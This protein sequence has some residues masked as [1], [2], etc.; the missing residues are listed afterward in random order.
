MNNVYCWFGGSY[1]ILTDNGTEFKNDLIDQVAKELGVEHKIFTPPYHPQSNGKI[2]AFH[3][4]LK[5]CIA[6]H[7]NQL[8]EWDEVV[9]LACAA[10]NFLP[11]EYS[12]ESPFFLMFGRDPILPLNKLLQP[13]IR[14]LGND[15]NILSLETLQ[16][17]YEL[18]ATNLTFARQ[19][20]GNKDPIKESQIKEGDLVLIK[21]NTKRGFQPRFLD[22]YRVV[23]IK[24]QQVEVRPAIGGDTKW[25]H[26]TH[27]KP[28]LPA[29]NVIASLPD[30]S[31]FGRKTTLRLNPDK[32]PDLNWNIATQLNTTLTTTNGKNTN[33]MAEMLFTSTN[34]EEVISFP[35][36]TF[37]V[38]RSK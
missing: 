27:V 31:A 30:Y 6:K 25:A 11:N 12:R 15:E 3:Y 5:A 22:N 21:N 10:Y 32:I 34:I 17:L 23:R 2:E 24:G 33:V 35:F 7:I 14:Y 9:P 29:D 37:I 1:K 26:I 36:E 13:K 4:F 8:G 19:R 38:K 20:Y 18:V 28:M 16:N